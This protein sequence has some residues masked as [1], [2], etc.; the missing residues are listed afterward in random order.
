MPIKW[1]S[2][3][4]LTWSGVITSHDHV[5]APVIL[6][7]QP[8]PNRFPWSAHAH[9]KRQQGKFCSSMGVLREQ[10][11]V[12]TDPCKIIDVAKLGHSNRGM[13]QQVRFNLFGC[14]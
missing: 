9:G 5:G 13:D 3:G 11:L 2:V 8:V 12:A 14:A 6:A 1:L 4:V 10:P 7:N